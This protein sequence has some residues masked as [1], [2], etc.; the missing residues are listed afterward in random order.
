MGPENQAQ[1]IQSQTECEKNE[2]FL[3][4]RLLKEAREEK[5]LT[6]SEVAVETRIRQVYI[7]ALEDGALDQLPGEIYKVGFLKTYSGFLGLDSL[8]ILRR[9]D[10]NQELQINYTNN[11]YI[12]PAESQSQPSKKILYLSIIGA[13]GFS[14]FAY[15]AHNSQDPEPAIENFIH[16]KQEAINGVPNESVSLEEANELGEG[17]VDVESNEE[18]FL[19]DSMG[20]EK[21]PTT[22]AGK[23][24]Q[25]PEEIS[26]TSLLAAHSL[27][28]D[29]KEQHEASLPTIDNQRNITLKAVKNTWVQVLDESGKSVYVK[30]MHAGDTHDLPKQGEYTLTTGNAG[31]LKVTCNGQETKILGSEGEIMRGIR[32][33][34]SGLQSFY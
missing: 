5:R 2:A 6:I 15:V 20:E 17:I 32:L 12:I 26:Q 22:I 1:E 25:V 19:S 24:S 34:E 8:E 14:I 16:E 7:K 18:I 30:L 13:L 23:K 31:G 11:K 29:M 28:K 21:E 10:L 9:L 3:I 27:S 33:T 4:G